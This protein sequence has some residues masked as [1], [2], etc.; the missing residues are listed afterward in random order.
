MMQ[1]WVLRAVAALAVLFTVSAGSVASAREFRINAG[2]E[3]VHGNS[4]VASLAQGIVVVWEG[5]GNIRARRWIDERSREFEVAPCCNAGNPRIA[6]L[7]DGGF[8]VVWS[9]SNDIFARRYDA[10]GNATGVAFPV[11]STTDSFQF[12]QAVAAL[13][14]GGFIVVW[15]SFA[16]DGSVNGVFGQRYAAAGTPTGEEFPVNRSTLNQQTRP[17]VA[18]FPAADGGGFVVVWQSDHD[19]S[20]VDIFGQRFAADGSTV[21]DEFLVE[22]RS[23]GNQTVADVAALDGQFV[24]VWES[25]RPQSGMQIFGRRFSTATGA[26]LGP[27]FRVN[28][29]SSGDQILP[30]VA[31]VTD[32]SF[33][34]V[35]QGP[36]RDGTGSDV[37]RR[38]FV[39]GEEGGRVQRV[40]KTAEGDQ[41]KPSVAVRSGIEPAM[42]VVW[43]VL[44]PGSSVTTL[45][46][47]AIAVTD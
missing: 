38:H 39:V 41:F 24:V 44:P 1:Q 12:N 21:G 32:T 20:D 11:N 18:G 16:Q 47:R 37:Y 22:Q 27:E 33:V 46:G 19:G 26:K 4:S 3:A 29:F 9:R 42:F 6:A 17:A 40:N 34:V 7:L 28:R 5:V 13:A 31:A 43:A 23:R 8:V 15:Q 2:P 30:R 10:E 35:W 45:R 25:E 14:D 36:G